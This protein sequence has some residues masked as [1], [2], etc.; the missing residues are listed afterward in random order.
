M[1]ILITGGNGFIGKNL[2]EQLRDKYEILAPGSKELDL[3]DQEQVGDYLSLHRFDVVIHTAKRDSVKY[4]I[5]D[6]E[7]LDS[8]LRMFYNLEKYSDLYGKMYYF[9]SG[10][11]YDVEH[12]IPSMKEGYFGTYIPK[13]PYG[14]SK[15]MMSK[16]AQQSSNIYD[17]RLFGVFGKYE[18]WSRRFISNV[19]CMTLFDMPIKMH[20]NM[21]FDYLYIDDLA[22]IMDQFMQI[23]PKHKVYNVCTGK[24]IDLYS[25]AQIVKKVSG[26]PYEIM[27]GEEGMKPEYTGN[28]DRLLAELAGFDFTDI[29]VA[30]HELY[31]YYYENKA[32]L[33]KENLR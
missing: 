30:I 6:Y 28:N 4:V 3:T 1:K 5:S 24:K 32:H 2:V 21:F 9:G 23:E 15:Y 29:E 27:V 10:A 16:T 12:Y 20:K 26:S 19:I 25:L 33:N 31:N 14:F 11:E 18:E 13:N 17:L 8:N 7:I 22:K